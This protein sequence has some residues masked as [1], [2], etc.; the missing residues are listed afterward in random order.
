MLFGKSRTP[1]GK[2]ETQKSTTP[3]DKTPSDTTVQKEGGSSVT[4]LD[5]LSRWLIP[6]DKIS[7]E[8]VKTTVPE[9]L[10]HDAKG[11]SDNKEATVQTVAAVIETPQTTNKR[12][13]FSSF[14]QRT[15]ANA[16][17]VASSSIH[18]SESGGGSGLK[19]GRGGNTVVSTL[20]P[21]CERVLEYWFGGDTQVNYRTK[22]FPT[23]NETIQR[24]ADDT[25]MN[26]FEEVF[27][28]CYL[29]E[30]TEEWSKH[31]RSALALIIVLDQFSRHIFRRQQVPPS[32][33]RRRQADVSAL[34][35]AVQLSST[36][37]WDRIFSVPEFVFALMPY[38]HART[39]DKLTI[40]MRE[41]GRREQEAEDGEKLL[42]KFR[43]QTARNLQAIQGVIHYY[44]FT[45]LP[46]HTTA[47]IHYPF[48]HSGHTVE[49]TGYHPLLHI[50]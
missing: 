25:I 16:S 8:S 2:G 18:D 39:V 12:S 49:H 37:T 40:V 13:S 17:A 11:N 43:K 6:D 1:L 41:I 30:K 7:S 46:F 47:L 14:F 28:L 23:G 36:P 38:R 32:D 35:V 21:M 31:P 50:F 20:D 26:L 33:S 5:R 34:A 3:P 27:Y 19:A 10:E 15:S 4:R 42:G 29:G 48:T 24:K 45:L 44:P 9:I 22:W